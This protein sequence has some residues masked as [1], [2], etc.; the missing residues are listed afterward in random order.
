MVK[1]G[2]IVHFIIK[3]VHHVQRYQNNIHML[4]EIFLMLTFYH[5]TWNTLN[6]FCINNI[7]FCPKIYSK[8]ICNGR[9]VLSH[10]IPRVDSKSLS[11]PYASTIWRLYFNIWG[12]G[13]HDA[14]GVTGI[15]NHM[16]MMAWIVRST[17]KSCQ[18]HVPCLLA[19]RFRY[20]AMTFMISCM[21]HVL[22]WNAT[23]V[24]RNRGN[25]IEILRPWTNM[26]TW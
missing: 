2:H 20:S 21:L 14:Y 23:C 6:V 13:L 5:L 18:A 19:K 26:E 10:V 4:I 7:S 3:F 12:L 22:H 9:V 24:E 15:I 25:A 11:G 16:W 1:G 17:P 8:H